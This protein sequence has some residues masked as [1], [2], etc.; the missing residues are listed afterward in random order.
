MKKDMPHAKEEKTKVTSSPPETVKKEIT[1][2]TEDS[3][4]TTSNLEHLQ[5]L[6]QRVTTACS[7]YEHENDDKVIKM[8][9][10]VIDRAVASI[11][12]SE[13]K[14]EEMLNTMVNAIPNHAASTKEAADA[15][16]VLKI[17]SEKL[18]S[19]LK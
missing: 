4:G 10:E 19:E 9:R 1:P 12:E 15:A 13:R 3:A 5:K 16:N 11:L 14:N 7:E 2:S 17:L 18:A 6:Q 8:Q